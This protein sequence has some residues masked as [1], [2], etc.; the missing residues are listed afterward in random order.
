MEDK[1]ISYVSDSASIISK[2][3]ENKSR[4]VG[5]KLSITEVEN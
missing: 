2:G 1:L 5:Q 4:E 3:K